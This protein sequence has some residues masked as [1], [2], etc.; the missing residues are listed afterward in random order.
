MKLTQPTFISIRRLIQL[1]VLITLIIATL[2]PWMQVNA[3][4]QTTMLSGQDLIQALRR[5]GYTLYFRHEATDWSQMDRIQKSNDW[6]S[7]DVSRI[8]QL[9]AA[10]RQS[11]VTTG[12]A[13]QSLAIPIGSVFASPYCRTVE[14]AKLMG[15]G[16]VK[17]TND[18][19]NM[20]VADYFGGRPAVVITARKLLAQ[21]PPINFNTLIVAHG[22]VARA[23][24][25]IYPG[26]GEGIVFE[27]HD[28]SGFRFIGRISSSEWQI[29]AAALE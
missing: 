17:P 1:A 3:A 12:R 15:L 25:S 11:A 13:I 26:E 24:T 29:L 27:P 21:P 22:N 6:L 10:G 5:G 18:V 23:S 19:I 7:C 2:P 9:S 8:R 4:E 20:R 28:A 14:T 16:K